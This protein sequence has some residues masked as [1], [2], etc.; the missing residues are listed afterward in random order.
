MKLNCDRGCKGN[1][2]AGSEGSILKNQWGAM[3]FATTNNYGYC[4]NMEAEAMALRDGLKI[5]AQKGMV[6]AGF[7]IDLDSLT[8][9]KIVEGKVRPP[10]MLW[11]CWREVIQLLQ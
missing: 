6:A 7:I 4:T 8:L 10:W 5:I 3:I 11:Y 1:P 9:V 2:G